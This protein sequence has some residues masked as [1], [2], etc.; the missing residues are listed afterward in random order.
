MAA[1]LLRKESKALK[2]E[3]VRIIKEDRYIRNI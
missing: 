1:G 3:A 2:R